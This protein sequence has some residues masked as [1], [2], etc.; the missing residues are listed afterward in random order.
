ML[1]PRLFRLRKKTVEKFFSE[2]ADIALPADLKRQQP[3]Y[4]E[5]FDWYMKKMGTKE[6]NIQAGAIVT[7]G[8][9]DCLGL[10]VLE[11]QGRHITLPIVP[12]YVNR[13]IKSMLG[14]DPKG[15]TKLLGDMRKQEPLLEKISYERACESVS[16][17]VQDKLIKE[18][19]GAYVTGMQLGRLLLHR[20]YPS[21]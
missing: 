14:E 1:N 12:E 3:H 18:F 19:Y 4:T 9:I 2:R 7:E 16:R 8:G 10:Y 21:S 20:T 17:S 6:Q 11:A 13:Q 5:F 15:L